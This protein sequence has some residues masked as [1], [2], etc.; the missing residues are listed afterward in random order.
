MLCDLQCF[1][2][3]SVSSLSD[4]LYFFTHYEA[5]I[6][7]SIVNSE[8]NQSMVLNR[9]ENIAFDMSDNYTCRYLQQ[10]LSDRTSTVRATDFCDFDT[11]LHFQI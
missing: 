2:I 5:W 10:N 4:S 6:V 1:L 3:D 7:V 9:G 11:A 8:L